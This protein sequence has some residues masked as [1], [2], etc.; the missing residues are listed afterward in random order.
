MKVA[1]LDLQAQLKRIGAEIKLA[2]AEVIDSGQS[3]GG[4]RVEELE[5]RI[6]DYVGAR[7]AIGVSLETDALVVGL[8]ALEV[9]PA[10][11]C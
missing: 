1:T 3:I 2:V 8:M 11:W 10:T 6:A 5:R 4:P 7:H 9:G